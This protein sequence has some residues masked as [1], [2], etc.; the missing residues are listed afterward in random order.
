MDIRGEIG[1]PYNSYPCKGG[2]KEDYCVI[3]VLNDEQ[4]KCFKEALGNPEWAE[5]AKYKTV[6][7]RIDAQVELD[8]HIAQWTLQHDKFEVM[9]LLQRHGVPSG[10]VQTTEERMDHDPQLKHRQLYQ[11]IEYP[12]IGTHRY[13]GMPFRMSETNPK[14]EERFPVLGQDN[15]YVLGQLLGLTDTEIQDLE[16]RGITWPKNTPK[17]ITVESSAW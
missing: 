5:E 12:E 7:S 9:E 2:G 14:F 1:A 10:A 13:E 6:E 8:E 4:W 16:V 11:Q 3:S 17:E 15:E